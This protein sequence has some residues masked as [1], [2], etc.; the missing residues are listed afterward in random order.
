MRKKDPDRMSQAEL[1]HEVK[2][3]REEHAPLLIKRYQAGY[4]QGVA[5]E[6]KR[7]TDIIKGK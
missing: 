3:S 5:D 6:N 7:V 4:T 2:K 1:R